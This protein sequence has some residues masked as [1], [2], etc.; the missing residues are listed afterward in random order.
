MCFSVSPQA[1]AS[2]SQR[3]PR[4][5]AA[6][7]APFFEA[8]SSCLSSLHAVHAHRANAARGRPHSILRS[9]M[10]R[11]YQGQR[12]GARADRLDAVAR[13]RPERVL[14]PEAVPGEILLRDPGIVG[15]ARRD[16]GVELGDARRDGVAYARAAD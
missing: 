11:A 4:S 14:V 6:V 7:A 5:G 10:R 16:L 13:E 1:L 15:G 2:G 9:A 8:L 12:S 3:A